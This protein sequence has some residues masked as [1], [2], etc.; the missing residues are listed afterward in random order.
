M[1]YS[2]LSI[3]A[4]W[5][6]VKTAPPREWPT[7]GE[8]IFENY[9][10]KYRPGLELVIKGITASIGQGEKVSCTGI[11]GLMEWQIRIIKLMY[12]RRRSPLRL[13][14]LAERVLASHRSLW[15]CSDWSSQLMAPFASMDSTLHNSGCIN[16]AKD[17]PSFPKT[18]YSSRE[19]FV[20]IWTLST[21]IRTKKFG[22]V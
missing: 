12:F 15:H 20:S 22:K 21:T 7:Q 11:R 3:E 1:E 19:R 14:S 8:I 10:T 6:I 4:A 5:N 18:L 2:E 9:T 17:W 16:C 13:A